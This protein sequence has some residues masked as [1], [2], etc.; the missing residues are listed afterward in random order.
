MVI[1]VFNKKTAIL[2]DGKS[3]SRTLGIISSNNEKQN[4]FNCYENIS[5]FNIMGNGLTINKDGQIKVFTDGKEFIKSLMNNLNGTTASINT[6]NDKNNKG[7]TSLNYLIDGEVTFTYDVNLGTFHVRKD[8]WDIFENKFNM[9]YIEISPLINEIA[10]KYL[11]IKIKSVG[12]SNLP[13][14]K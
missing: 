9:T 5:F 4:N 8:I 10:K 2:A 14:Q 1:S 7:G 13:L 11:N 12:Y 3:Y 6:S